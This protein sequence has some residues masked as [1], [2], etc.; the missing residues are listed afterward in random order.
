MALDFLSKKSQSCS[1][2]SSCSQLRLD[3]STFPYSSK[4]SQSKRSSNL[5]LNQK[6]KTYNQK[7]SL[8]TGD[9]KLVMSENQSVVPPDKENTP[10]NGRKNSRSLMSSQSNTELPV[11]VERSTSQSSSRLEHET[12]VSVSRLTQEQSSS[13]TTSSLSDI[14]KCKLSKDAS[15][16]LSDIVKSAD[17][18]VV[19]RSGN[20]NSS[21][22]SLS[23]L[24]RR[25]M[26][27]KSKN[28][29]TA[30]TGS[31]CQK[32]PSPSLSLLA[33]LSTSP[34][35]VTGLSLSELSKSHNSAKSS[36]CSPTGRLQLLHGISPESIMS[37]SNP[38]IS[39]P[40]QKEVVDL[41]TSPSLADLA[42]SHQASSNL[43]IVSK[44][45]TSQSSIT[46]PSL[47]DRINHSEELKHNEL[48]AMS[49]QDGKVSHPLKTKIGEVTSSI[50]TDDQA[51]I[52]SLTDLLKPKQKSSSSTMTSSQTDLLKNKD[53]KISSQADIS[54][55]CV[56]DTGSKSSD[57]AYMM[58]SLAETTCRLEAHPSTLGKVLVARATESFIPRTKV[59][60]RF[61]RFSYTQQLKH[62]KG[63]NVVSM[64]CENKIDCFD[65]STPS[66]DD[67]VKVKQK[68][69][70]I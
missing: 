18:P 62:L 51:P 7:P 21:G 40:R 5:V 2:S 3:S 52:I 44:S 69:A 41:A 42:K 53:L 50:K 38:R 29:T 30:S 33:N 67:I 58:P 49:K 35:P 31:Q 54:T 25:H 10:P 63:V 45:K 55:T 17:S 27:V 37:E 8:Q 1:S 65:F 68:E 14:L 4:P 36:P 43:S 16:S 20:E 60:H 59:G 23:S 48:S 22:I 32:V 56:A 70:F 46:S 9:S 64:V 19:P 11:M 61:L 28:N 47:G 12:T 66:P 39:L 26:D 24:M 6:T 57:F 15:M 13:L 34:I